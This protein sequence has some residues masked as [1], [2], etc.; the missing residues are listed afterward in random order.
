MPVGAYILKAKE[1]MEVGLNQKSL[2][3]ALMSTN[4]VGKEVGKLSTGK[5]PGTRCQ[6]YSQS[7][8]QEKSRNT[9]FFSIHLVYTL[10]K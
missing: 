7:S 5:D 2:V 1:A 10:G 3:F 9:L 4:A 6:G 8:A